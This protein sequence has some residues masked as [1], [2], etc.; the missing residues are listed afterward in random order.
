[1]QS[2]LWKSISLSLGLRLVKSSSKSCKSVFLF[3]FLAICF[4]LS[5]YIERQVQL[6]HLPRDPGTADA[7]AVQ[8]RRA[9]E[10][11]MAVICMMGGFDVV[12]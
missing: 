7:I 3:F 6:G 10:K 2:R 9:R 1:M 12:F 5:I 8:M 4:F 11:M